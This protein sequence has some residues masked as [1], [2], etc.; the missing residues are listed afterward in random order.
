MQHGRSFIVCVSCRGCKR[1]FCHSLLLDWADYAQVSAAAKKSDYLC[2]N[3][4]VSLETRDGIIST[5]RVIMEDQTHLTV[6]WWQRMR[7]SLTNEGF[8]RYEVNKGNPSWYS[9]T[10]RAA[11]W[12]KFQIFYFQ[13]LIWKELT[14]PTSIPVGNQHPEQ[15]KHRV[16]CHLSQ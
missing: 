3:R 5:G 16:K 4:V 12:S 8:Y 14:F 6:R 15:T 13:F 2:P 1:T 10:V 11:F 9:L 7:Q